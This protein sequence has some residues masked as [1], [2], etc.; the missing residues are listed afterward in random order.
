[1]ALIKSIQYG[2]V[3]IA[4]AS[5]TSTAT[6]TSVNTSTA[7]V[8][9]LGAYGPVTGTDPGSC[10]A[11]VQITSGTVVTATRA[12][13]SGSGSLTVSFIVTE[14]NPSAIQSVTQYATAMTNVTSASQT[15]SP[16]VTA[17]NAVTYWGGCTSTNTA[18][19]TR[20]IMPGISGLTSSA[21]SVVCGVTTS[22]LTNT[23]YYTV[24]EF[25]S[26]VLNSAVQYGSIAF[27]IGTASSG[28]ATISS[29]NTT[30]S[31][32]CFLGWKYLS[33][34]ADGAFNNLPIL[35]L[36]NSTTVTSQNNFSGSAGNTLTTYF[37]IVE[38]KASDIKSLQS[39]T[40]S[41]TSSSTTGSSTISSVNPALTTLSYLGYFGST[42]SMTPGEG[43]VGVTLTNATTVSIT[44]GIGDTTTAT[45]G[46]QSLQYASANGNML[47]CF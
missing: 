27:T 28:T 29:I 15:L 42:A 40:T 19:T 47:L 46:W 13:T 8:E 1:M 34:L 36:T 11:G 24:V 5:L 30:S 10:M 35:S 22:G 26:G 23:P 16:T 43:E 45:V 9:F 44:R 20:A 25:K 18:S 12:L 39:G 6:I 21:V 7:V 3:V 37:C 38:F 17:A 4:A 2:V 31:K 41:N 32:L 14:Y 33:V